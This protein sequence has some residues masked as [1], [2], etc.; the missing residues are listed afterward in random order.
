MNESQDSLIIKLNFFEGDT[1][2]GPLDLLLYLIK[3][4][5]VDIYDIPVGLITEQY[6]AY[7]EILQSLNLD[8]AGDFLV[9]AAT[10][11]QIKSKLLLPTLSDEE[12]PEDEEDPRMSLVRPLIEYAR[13]R[14]AAE[15]LGERFLLDRDVFT[16]GSFDDFDQPEAPQ[17]P[18]DPSDPADQSDPSAPDSLPALPEEPPLRISLFQLVDAWKS[19]AGKIPKE[20]YGIN[21][22]LET[23]TIG[24]KLKEIKGFLLEKKSAHFKD[25]FKEGQGHLTTSLSFLA[26]LELAR[27]G[28]LSLYQDNEEDLT[29]PRLFLSN[30]DAETGLE[31]DYR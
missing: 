23:V 16:R 26:T 9:M 25:L 19:L 14:T 8:A 20:S 6:L 7:L 21:F 22:K 3:R 29:G 11:T 10:L 5:E 24:E 27:T 2:D 17:N 12:T 13:L 28:F 30:P 15:A 31:F 4:N 1:F 18:A